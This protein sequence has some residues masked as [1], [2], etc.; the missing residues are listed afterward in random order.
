MA[1][2]QLKLN[3]GYNVKFTLCCRL[4]KKEKLLERKLSTLAEQMPENGLASSHVL[5]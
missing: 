5:R 1:F 3:E 4:I 2:E